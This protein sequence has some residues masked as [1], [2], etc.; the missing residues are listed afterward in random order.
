MRKTILHLPEEKIRK[1]GW[2]VLVK[3]LG[4]SGATRFLLEYQSGEGNYVK[5]RRK[6]FLGKT[7]KELGEEI[8]KEQ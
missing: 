1:E 6:L 4:V 7:A 2:E 3:K 8:L 5:E